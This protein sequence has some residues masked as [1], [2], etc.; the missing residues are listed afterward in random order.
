[1]NEARKL[2]ETAASVETETKTPNAA[3]P[4]T[5]TETAAAL[6]IA[7]GGDVTVAAGERLLAEEGTNSG[8]VAYAGSLTGTVNPL[9]APRP[10]PEATAPFTAA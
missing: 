9:T 3:P 7:K 2:T 1:M 5:A 8:R 10:D 6:G 4:A